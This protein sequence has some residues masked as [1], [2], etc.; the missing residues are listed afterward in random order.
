MPSEGSL[1]GLAYIHRF[2]L[3]KSPL[4][5]R[6][7]IAR[8]DPSQISSPRSRAVVRIKAR[9]L[10]EV[11]SVDDAFPQAEE[12]PLGF[13]LGNEIVGTCQDMTHVRLLDE[14]RRA[15]A[16]QLEE[17]EHVESGG[18]SK[19]VAD[20]SGLQARQGLDVQFRQPLLTAPTHYTSLKRIRRIGVRGG[21]PGELRAVPEPPD[22]LL[23]AG[24]PAFQ[25]L[26]GRLLGYPDQNV[27]DV[28]FGR[29]VFSFALLE[30]QILD[31]P[32]ADRDLAG[33]FA[34]PQAIHQDLIAKFFPKRV[35]TDRIALE[36]L[37]EFG[38]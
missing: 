11:H 30:Q 1:D 5:F 33:D 12:L 26:G 14:E 9:E 25:L 35:E 19:H 27:L 13:V 29:S 3:R 28:V 17:L 23:G 38:Q 8:I 37:P 18:A 15:G 2:Q 6:H 16:A 7:G 36:R 20:V 21:E 22:H 10:R 31:L 24:T 34:V 4:E 32:F